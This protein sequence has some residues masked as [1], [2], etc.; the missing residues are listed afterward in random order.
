MREAH[1]KLVSVEVAVTI[2]EALK[3]PP[4]AAGA[5]VMPVQP[6]KD[7]PGASADAQQAD[8]ASS[9]GPAPG[10]PTL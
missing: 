6:M 7:A 3:L 8:R 2:K 1:Q 10:F 4:A 9:G 5:Q